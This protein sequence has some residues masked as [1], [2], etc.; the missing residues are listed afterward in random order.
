MST[1]SLHLFAE[2]IFVKNQSNNVPLAPSPMP[3]NLS[4]T[5]Q[6]SRVESPSE[7]VDTSGATLVKISRPAGF[8]T[9]M[10]VVNW[11][12][13]EI[14]SLKVFFRCKKTRWDPRRS[15]TGNRTCRPIVTISRVHGLRDFVGFARVSRWPNRSFFEFRF[16]VWGRR[17]GQLSGHFLWRE[18]EAE[19]L[20]GMECR[21]YS[22]IRACQRRVH[23]FRHQGLC[24][25]CVLRVSQNFAIVQLL[26]P[27][28]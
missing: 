4:V 22:S 15:W 11:L 27:R 8:T 12:C 14:Y 10:K 19:N 1:I 28:S 21:S 3:P 9:F 5:P 7:S 23:L 18:D 25:L 26:L 16:R 2:C 24:S 13:S 17:S 6:I 20:Q